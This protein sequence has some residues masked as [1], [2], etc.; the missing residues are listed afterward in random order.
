MA[1]ITMLPPLVLKSYILFKAC[2]LL[3]LCQTPVNSGCQPVPLPSRQSLL[4]SC[5]C[6]FLPPLL[7]PFTV[8]PIRSFLFLFLLLFWFCTPPHFCCT[9]RCPF[10]TAIRF[11]FHLDSHRIYFPSFIPAA[12]PLC[13]SNLAFSNNRQTAQRR[14]PISL[15][16][17]LCGECD[18]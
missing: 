8:W 7:F 13:R 18:I 17:V 4:P 1:L 2:L 10:Y 14:N 11:Q 6:F 12:S 16:S 15:L 9:L 3:G 5:L